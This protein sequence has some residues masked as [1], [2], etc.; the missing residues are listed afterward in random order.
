MGKIRCLRIVVL[1][2]PG[3]NWTLGWVFWT[4]V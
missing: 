3:C 2:A 4:F 1:A